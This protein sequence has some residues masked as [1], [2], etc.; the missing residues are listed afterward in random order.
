[1]D[2]VAQWCDD[3]CLIF[4]HPF[5]HNYHSYRVHVLV[6]AERTQGQREI[7]ADLSHWSYGH[8]QF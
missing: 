7:S 6:Q 4:I 2:L 1:M 3:Y 8:P 5:P